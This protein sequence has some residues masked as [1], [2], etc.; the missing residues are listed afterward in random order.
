MTSLILLIAGTGSRLMPFTKDRPKCMV[1]LA[2]IPILERQLSIYKNFD[3]KKIIGVCGYK[4]EALTHFKQIHLVENEK[5][6]TT[7]ISSSLQIGLKAVLS[8][9]GGADQDSI[10]ISYGDIIFHPDVFKKIYTHP[11][12]FVT[13]VDQEYLK[14][15]SARMPDPLSDLE[16]LKL[17]ADKVI[18][19]ISGKPK[20]YSE[21]DAQY[22]G[23][24]KMSVRVARQLLTLLQTNEDNVT[25]LS[26][27]HFM[28][29][30]IQ[31]KA[32]KLSACPI[33]SGWV[34]IDST[35]DLNELE[36]RLSQFLV[37]QE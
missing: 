24:T 10:I 14:L 2:G 30:L 4:K 27:T 7:N 29:Y 20:N 28:N 19:E 21:I 33:K 12:E 9:V 3:L 34:E 23:L 13:V 36:P 1:P 6:A 25:S 18:L 15:W 17:S 37:A 31:K 11:G 8:D 16:T 35:A 26:M 32:M 22:I 5:Y